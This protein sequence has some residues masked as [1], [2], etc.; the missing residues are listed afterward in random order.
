MHHVAM[1]ETP[2]SN[3]MFEPI[4]ITGV[5]SKNRLIRSSIGGRTAYYEGYVNEAWNI[6]R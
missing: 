2:L 3:Q 4:T 6:S 5:T 1:P